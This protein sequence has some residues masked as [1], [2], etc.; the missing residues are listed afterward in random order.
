MAKEF[1]LP[2][3]GEGLT[4][5]EIVRWLVE[6]GG[7]VEA[8]ESVVEVETDKAVVEIPSPYAGV[9]L[10][11]G[12]AEGDVV[13][14]GQILVVVG[15]EDEI[16]PPED[17]PAEETEVAPIVGTLSSEAEMLS[18]RHEPQEG[19]AKSI[20]ALPLVR[21]LARDLDVD[22]TA[23]EGTGPEG[24]IVREDVLAA[25]DST[26]AGPEGAEAGVAPRALPPVPSVPASA[27]ET[28]PATGGDTSER[29]PLSKLR[30]TI[31]ANMAA[32][33]AEV[34]HVTTFD[35][36]DA[37]RLLAMRS[38]LSRRHD[39]KIPMEALVVKAVVGPLVAFPELNSTLEGDELVL[40]RRH[41]IGIAV[42]TPDGLLV[43]V[44]RNAGRRSVLALSEDV[45]R[46]GASARERKLGP[47]E[48]T[49]QTFTVSNI[50]ALG[51]GFGTPIV[52]P[53][54]VAILSVGRARQKPVAVEGTVTV[55]PVLPLSLS[56]DHRVIDGGLGRRFMALLIE[57]LEEPTL[58]LAD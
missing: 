1:R 51:G 42:D 32:S 46:L 50:G 37:T 43:A 31:A 29:R 11:H 10:H 20:K 21:K 57:N 5:A 40:H 56:Y 3:I 6:V 47:E 36:V 12:G 44:V 2:D 41:D 35:E 38:A 13:E 9:V 34:P 45:Q 8:D 39:T 30:R 16:W 26:G 54:T 4:E 53:G 24:R 14:V 7:H 15:E 52:P 17:E 22:L 19:S 27:Q 23:V 49:G 58:F 25:A 18:P 55:A 48:L 28:I 33:W